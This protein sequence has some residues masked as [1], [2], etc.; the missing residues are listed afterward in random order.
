MTTAIISHALSSP[1]FLG[2]PRLLTHI[3]SL[4]VV[5]RD[6]PLILR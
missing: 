5:G 2:R 3:A 1:Q 4:P 6:I